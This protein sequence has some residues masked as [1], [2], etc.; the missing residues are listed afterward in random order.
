M[1]V[2]NSLFSKNTA[3]QYGG[4]LF[5]GNGQFEIY[6]SEFTGN[7]SGA[8]GGAIATVFD[9]ANTVKIVRSTF[10]ENKGTLVVRWPSILAL[11]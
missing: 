7:T 4:A 9:V 6:D 3:S 8:S 11:R 5:H 10:T 1:I 2:R